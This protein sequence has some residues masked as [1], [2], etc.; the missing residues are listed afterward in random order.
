MIPI[1]QYIQLPLEQRKAHLKLTEPCLERGGPKRRGNLSIQCRALVAHV[2]GT[3][4]PHG[5]KIQVCHACNNS[6]CSSPDHLYWGTTSDN[7]QD[8]PRPSI[9]NSMVKKYGE[10]QAR[11]MQTRTKNFYSDIASKGNKGKPKSE[12]HRRKLSEKATASWNSRR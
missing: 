2:L 7:W 8:S 5:H 11:N 9:W 3:S 1:E 10:E 4:I 12:E 6:E